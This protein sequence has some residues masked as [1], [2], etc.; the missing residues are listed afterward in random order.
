MALLLAK[1]VQSAHTKDVFMPTHQPQS[2]ARVE[3]PVS[4]PGTSLQAQSISVYEGP[5]LEDESGREV[6]DVAALHIYNTG[7][8]EILSACITV[9]YEDE[10]Y[11]FYGEHIPPEATV[12]LLEMDAKAYRQ[13]AITDCSGWQELSDR[14]QQQGILITDQDYGTLV[15]TNTTDQALRNISLYYKNWLSPPDVYIG[16]ITYSA[17]ILQLAPGQTRMLLPDHYATGYS[18]VVSVTADP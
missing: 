4:V 16:G 8:Q 14:T 12:V 15:V 11:V 7:K 13:E 10:S 9:Q 6:V 2:S 5:F 18:K 1:S 17:S 3:L